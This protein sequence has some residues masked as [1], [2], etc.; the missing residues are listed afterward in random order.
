MYKFGTLQYVNGDVY[1][2]GA[3][4]W[5][6]G[7]GVNLVMPTARQLDSWTARQLDS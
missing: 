6:S 3:T 7:G 1:T 4:R 2:G 5:N